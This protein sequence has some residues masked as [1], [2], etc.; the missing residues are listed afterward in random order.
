MNTN[1]VHSIIYFASGALLAFNSFGADT[2]GAEARRTVPFVLEAREDVSAN[3]P[4]APRL[5]SFAWAQ[6]EG[7][8][9]FIAGRTAGYHGP[10]ERR[11][12]LPALRLQREN[13]DG[14]PAATGSAQ[15]WSVP[16]ADLPPPS[17][18]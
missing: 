1:R 17:T 8:W 11:L 7:K 10:A 13:L 12:G 15:T 14:R 9:I 4:G 5:Q 2:R 18:R 16:V 6:W 3:F